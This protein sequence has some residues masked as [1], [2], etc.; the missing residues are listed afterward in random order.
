MIRGL[1]PY[2]PER[3]AKP[4]ARMSRMIR[5]KLN[6]Q[7]PRTALMVRSYFAGIQLR[8]APDWAAKLTLGFCYLLAVWGTKGQAMPP[9]WK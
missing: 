4:G 6:A 1:M 9:S 2:G 5:A 3:F 7:P 8:Q